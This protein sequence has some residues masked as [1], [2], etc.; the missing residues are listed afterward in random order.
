MLSAQ[1]MAKF[2]ANKAKITIDINGSPH[3]VLTMQGHE[4][5]SNGFHFVITLLTD[6][7]SPLSSYI[8]GTTQLAFHGQDGIVTKIN[9]LGWKDDTR[10]TVEL[11]FESN[12]AR[13]KHQTD[14]RI[15]LGHSVPDLIKLTCE[16]NGLL[17]DQLHFDL[18]RAYPVKP[19][20]LQ[21][22][23]TDWAFI[24]RLAANSGLYFYSIAKDDQEVIVFTDHNAHCPYIAREVLHF[25]APS[26]GNEDV[27]GQAVVGVH[28]LGA[29]ARMVIPQ[30]R[31]NDVNE[32]TPSTS[33]LANTAIDA[34]TSIRTTPQPGETVFGLG[35]RSL[36]ESDAH[37]KRIAE[38]A[39]VTAFDLTARGNVVD[40]AA[41]H[42]C[43]LE[44]SHFDAQYNA[45][46]F[47]S[48]VIHEA[49]QFAGHNEGDQD[50]AYRHIATCI[51]RETPFRTATVHHPE[52]PMTL[53]ARIESDGPY[54][55]L[56]E[57]GKYQL[58]ALFDLSSTQH[59]QAM[60]PMRRVSPYGGLPNESNVGFHTPLHDG[61][62]VLI[63]CLNGDPDRPMLVGTVPNPERVS[64]VTSANSS[65]NRLRTMSDNELTF[66][67]TKEKEAITLRTYEGHNILHLNAE[68]VGHKVRL[69]T[70]HGAM[71]TFA[72]KTIHRQSD[73]TMTERVGNDRLVKVKNMHR[74][75]TQTKEIHHQAK[76][77][78]TH[79]AYK[80]MQTESGKNTELK[81]GR[82]MVIDVEDNV[83]L[84]IKGSGGLY[85]TVKSN[86]VFIQSANKID[87]KG[88]GGGDITF[89]QS[90]GGFKVGKSGVVSFYGKKVFFGGSGGV[91]LNG[92]VNYS[93]PGPNPPGAVTTATP[94]SFTGIPQII[95][96]K[97]LKLFNLIW[98]KKRL[99]PD[100]KLLQKFTATNTTPK[101]KANIQTYAVNNTGEKH[102]VSEQ[103]MLLAKGDGEYK[104]EWSRSTKELQQ[105]LDKYKDKN[106]ESPMFFEF[107]VKSDSTVSETSKKIFLPTTYKI[108][109]SN[110]PEGKGYI[111]VN[112]PYVLRK[113]G[114]IIRE[115]KTDNTGE[116]YVSCIDTKIIYT[117]EILGHE[118]TLDYGQLEKYYYWLDKPDRGL[119]ERLNIL[120]Y[121]LNSKDTSDFYTRDETK[122]IGMFM[123][124]SVTSS[125]LQSVK[126][127]PVNIKQYYIPFADVIKKVKKYFKG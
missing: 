31:V 94:V 59:T 110:M 104:L 1:G 124:K 20:T 73:D 108:T 67:D 100:K 122:L 64:P 96:D 83:N 17:K 71:V 33:L 91:Q 42:I 72:K 18:S 98:D 48:E 35:T 118:H 65:V 102:L 69:A 97:E 103:N 60:I 52:L 77:D 13:L 2:P 25:I 9:E 50:I 30:S 81:T 92:K 26:G 87:V 3:S 38:H 99:T 21:A 5:V 19:Y 70:E 23:E 66:D 8:G 115:A 109:I 80:N 51:K 119:R 126:T 125:P 112:E 90:G 15:I 107:K 36:D 53:T 39:K 57:Q 54:A 85:A 40:M 61:D 127:N 22:N 78:H 76:T 120:G 58:R 113:N 24:S 46:Y 34:T 88:K 86:D 37:S 63:S 62:E 29:N 44:A 32:E 68:A 75:E 49:S 84:T 93:V 95:D 12:L 14:T 41:G 16:R 27:M 106:G 111:Y 47:I 114:A 121:N 117:L 55:R 79:A 82:H 123:G 28:H 101:S 105:D 7:Y 45:D 74:T 11:T 56:D 10:L 43:S 4:T 6:K 89:E 116:I